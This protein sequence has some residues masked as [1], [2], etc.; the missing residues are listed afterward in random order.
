M[1]EENARDRAGYA[2]RA[3]QRVCDIL[4]LLQDAADGVSLV[5]VAQA[6]EL[7]KSSA[8]RYLATLES[9]RYVERDN[10]TG[11]YRL[12]LAF[13]PLHSR[14]LDALTQRARPAL[15]ALRDEFEETCNLGMLD[16]GRVV[17]L[18]IVESMRSMRLA[19]RRGDR[20]PIHSTALGKAIAADLPPDRVRAILSTEG[21]PKMT[22]HTLTTQRAYFA[23]LEEVRRQG[24][25]LDDGENESDG[26]CV[27]VALHGLRIPAAISLS[28][29]ATR[30]PL[31]RVPDA[32]GALTRAT[33]QLALELGGRATADAR[34]R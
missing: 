1:S 34:A 6:A 29:P 15:E 10:A 17:Y 27:A 12:G 33:E 32:V 18:D 2:I 16:G 19:A 14:Q 26:R 21:M 5:E 7:P 9:R 31:E 28:A 20:D 8:F 3:V 11:D 13:L 24:Y 30:L 25:A 4:D 22:A 23:A